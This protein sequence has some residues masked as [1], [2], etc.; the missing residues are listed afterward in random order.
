MARTRRA[1]EPVSIL[2]QSLGTPGPI[3]A[4]CARCL[5]RRRAS[6]PLAGPTLLDYGN[7]INAALRPGM[8]YVGGTDNGRWI[9]ELL[10]DTSDGEQHIV[11]TQNALADGRYLDFVNDLYGERLSTLTQDESKR[12]FEDYVSDAQKRF[13]HDQQFP[14][15]PKQVLPGEDIQVVDGKVQVRGQVA[16]MAINERLLQM[17]MQ[18]ESGD[19]LRYRGI[20]SASWHLCRRAPARSFDGVER[21]Q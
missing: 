17:L 11:V 1:F 20:V 19:V 12:A 2:D 16:V 8:V 3:L 7:A 15:E 14:D 18:K 5:W 4:K 21:A 6:P 13:D 10:N 9:P